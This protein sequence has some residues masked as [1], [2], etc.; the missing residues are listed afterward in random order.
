[1][2]EIKMEPGWGVWMEGDGTPIGSLHY[3]KVVPG[4]PEWDEFEEYY[5]TLCGTKPRWADSVDTVPPLS[6]E[7]VCLRCIRMTNG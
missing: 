5:R 1:M 2:A 6:H 7:R 4:D 3:F